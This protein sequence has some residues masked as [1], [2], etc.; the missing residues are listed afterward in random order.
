MGTVVWKKH[1][2]RLVNSTEVKM[3]STDQ[4]Q[5]MNPKTSKILLQILRIWVI[6]GTLLSAY[7]LY[8]GYAVRQQQA[9][10]QAN[11]DHLVNILKDPEPIR[12]DQINIDSVQAVPPVPPVPVDAGNIFRDPTQ[13]Q[14]VVSDKH[15]DRE[16]RGLLNRA[17]DRLEAAHI[18]YEKQDMPIDAE[19]T[20]GLQDAISPHIEGKTRRLQNNL[21]SSTQSPLSKRYPIIERDSHGRIK[22]SEAAKDD[23]KRMSPCPANGHI[24]GP[25][26]GY[27]IDHVTALA[28]GGADA[29]SNMQW[30]TESEGKAKD[31]W[32]RKDCATS[33]PSNYSY[34]QSYSVSSSPASSNVGYYTGKRGGCY[35]L[36]ASGHKDYVDHSF[37]R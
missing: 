35:K 30:Q 15:T 31:K 18:N 19:L 5:I 12:S 14:V 22:R 29:P 32:E 37:C 3:T 16:A 34:F 28:C 1:W 26:P 11:L 6:G 2:R 21:S 7:F 4:G 36:T 25:C 20:A 17:A 23:F 8:S 33:N 24:S 10:L 13:P 9:E 27:V